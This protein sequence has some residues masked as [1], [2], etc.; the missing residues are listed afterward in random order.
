MEYIGT[1]LEEVISIK[2]IF[3]I[4]YFEYMSNYNF[5]GE[6]H[7][8]WELLYVD[9]GEVEV[10]AD[11]EHFVCKHDEIIFHKPNEFHALR[12]NG[13]VA[14]NLVVLSFSCLS[15]KMKFFENKRL[16]INSQE[17]KIISQIIMEARK[18]FSSPLDKTY[19][20]QLERRD[21][22]YFG[23]E[24]MI[25]ICLEQF[26]ISLLRRYD[27]FQ[28]S[29]EN[30]LFG[31]NKVMTKEN[32]E[33][34]IYQRVTTYMNEHIRDSLTM[35]EICKEILIS[36]SKLQNIFHS[37][38]GCGVMHYFS[39]LKI[40]LG[41]QL[42]REGHMNF[43]EIADNLGYTSVHYFSRQ[44]KKITNMTP[45]EYVSSVKGLSE[46]P[47]KEDNFGNNQTYKE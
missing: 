23:S 21:D 24:Q 31:N 37:R 14:P 28:Q 12:A 5:E 45:S 25:R 10:I 40:D 19:L 27:V 35:E 44:F 3:S 46:T 22:A 26:I 18:A 38:H 13:V 16:Q 29:K 9:K 41:K 39:S 15:E 32:Y 42:M 17:K 20:L 36:R 7:D 6:R 30:N 4:H 43:T 11:D 34:Y 1:K 47:N 33:K 8:F 2:E